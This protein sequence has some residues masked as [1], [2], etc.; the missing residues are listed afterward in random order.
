MPSQAQVATRT[1]I[2][3]NE[4]SG[5]AAPNSGHDSTAAVKAAP[6][7]RRFAVWEP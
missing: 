2:Q 7:A 3:A 5:S 1:A 4:A 6:V